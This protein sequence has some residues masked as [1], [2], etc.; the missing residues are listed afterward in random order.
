MESRGDG[1]AGRK[2]GIESVR[3]DLPFYAILL[4]KYMYHPGDPNG[5]ATP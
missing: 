2:V 4:V 3:P 1:V 5:I